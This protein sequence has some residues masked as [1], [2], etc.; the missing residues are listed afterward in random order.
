MSNKIF[1][2]ANSVDTGPDAASQARAMTPVDF[3]SLGLGAVAYL[4]PIQLPDG[5]QGLRIND[6]MG[7]PLAVAASVIAAVEM[8]EA[9]DLALVNLQ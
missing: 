4:R 8:A 7:R 2:Q 3:A 1:N 6:A 9:A 5:S